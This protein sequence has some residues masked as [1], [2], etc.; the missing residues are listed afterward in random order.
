M[1]FIFLGR[2]SGHDVGSRG[3]LCPP[4]RLTRAGY[5]PALRGADQGTWRLDPR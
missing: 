1:N 4:I 2:S 5:K 3:A